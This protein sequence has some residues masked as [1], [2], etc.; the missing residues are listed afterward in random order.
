[1]SDLHFQLQ[2]LQGVQCTQ[3]ASDPFPSCKTGCTKEK[4]E[5][6]HLSK[7]KMPWFQLWI[8]NKHNGFKFLGHV[9]KIWR[10]QTG[11]HCLPRCF[12]PRNPGFKARHASK[13]LWS[14]GSA[15]LCPGREH[16]RTLTPEIGNRS[17]DV[18]RTIFFPWLNYI[19]PKRNHLQTVA[20]PYLRVSTG[21]PEDW[22][23]QTWPSYPRNPKKQ[24]RPARQ[25]SPQW[26]GRFPGWCRPRQLEEWGLQHNKVTET[27]TVM[28]WNQ[29][30]P[31]TQN[32]V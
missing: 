19:K 32:R 22:K 14:P 21:G 8:Q 11:V 15:T 12:R 4:S 7:E 17:S 23:L 31:M 2:S 16:L 5:R 30:L 25:F 20:S 28:N 27:R 29:W 6:D 13:S 9:K 18:E 26:P 1:M 24:P 3:P 10:V